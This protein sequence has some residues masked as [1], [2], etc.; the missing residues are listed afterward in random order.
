MESPMT[1]KGVTRRSL[2]QTGGGAVLVALIGT[3]PWSVAK[4]M[5]AQ[6]APAYLR[7]SSYLAL[8]GTTFA[9][10]SRSLRLDEVTGDRDDVFGLTFTG[11]HLEQGIHE[12]RHPQLGSFALFV[13]PVGAATDHQAV[14][15]RSI[16]LPE[17][18][19]AIAA[20]AAP[21][22]PEPSAGHQP[23][24][25]VQPQAAKHRPLLRHAR[26]RRAGHGLRCEVVLRH[27]VKRVE[28]RLLRAGHTVAKGHRKLHGEH[29]T[30]RLATRH[31]LPA[32]EYRLLVVTTDLKG[33]V[34]SQVTIVRIP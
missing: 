4:A 16:K 33:H 22:A 9:A 25:S 13:A 15:D 14:V 8:I 1:A 11:D 23:P 7:R 30:V 20:A 31:R 32:G 18:Q 17:A 27:A 5:A 2:L 24:E 10:G 19:A 6:D 12:L 21:P 26:L 3:G 28:L 34:T 29:A